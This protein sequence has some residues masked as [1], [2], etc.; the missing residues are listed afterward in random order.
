LFDLN[1]SK[2]SFFVR[3][4][5][6]FETLNFIDRAKDKLSV[7]NRITIQIGKNGL[8][9]RKIFGLTFAFLFFTEVLGPF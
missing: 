9:L 6:K 7:K 5:G 1:H 3:K 8:K 2:G 4:R